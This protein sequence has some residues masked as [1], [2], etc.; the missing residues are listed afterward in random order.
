MLCCHHW[1]SWWQQGLGAP[2]PG[3]ESYSPDKRFDLSLLRF[4]FL[5]RGDNDVTS[6]ACKVSDR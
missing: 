2:I 6:Q 3:S 5:Q 1:Q 4:P